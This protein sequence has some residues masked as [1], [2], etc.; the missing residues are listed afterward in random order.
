V[1]GRQPGG[2]DRTRIGQGSA[3]TRAR[4]R[5]HTAR[6]NR[7]QVKGL[8]QSRHREVKETRREDDERETPLGVV[9]LMVGK[10]SHSRFGRSESQQW[11]ERDKT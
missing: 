4:S 8:S 7:K 2:S 11:E 5:L 1:G 9:A 10:S 6:A 3:Q